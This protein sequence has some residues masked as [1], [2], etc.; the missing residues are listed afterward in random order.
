MESESAA[1]CPRRVIDSPLPRDRISQPP[2]AAFSRHK[3]RQRH[4]RRDAH[5]D[6][7]PTS[8]QGRSDARFP[9][10]PAR[11]Q[12]RVLPAATFVFETK[13]RQK[14]RR[15]RQQKLPGGR[16]LSEA[17]LSEEE[18]LDC[19]NQVGTRGGSIPDTRGQQQVPRLRGGSLGVPTLAPYK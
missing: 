16:P 5:H 7:R 12:Q 2:P 13:G 18:L 19:G 1:S 8:R 9:T 3:P 4:A 14:L 17:I 6:A 10:P 11:G 15:R